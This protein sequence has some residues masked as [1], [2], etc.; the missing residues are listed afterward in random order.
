MNPV[1]LLREKSIFLKH[2]EVLGCSSAGVLGT[3]RN[4]SAV[5]LHRRLRRGRS[6]HVA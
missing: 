2:E 5:L 6:K 1:L 3:P 4:R